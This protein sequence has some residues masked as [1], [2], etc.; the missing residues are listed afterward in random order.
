M[1]KEDLFVSIYPLFQPIADDLNLPLVLFGM[2][3]TTGESYDQQANTAYLSVNIIWGEETRPYLNGADGQNCNSIIQIDCIYPKDRGQEEL[4]ALQ[5]AIAVK[6]KIPLDSYI[7]GSVYNVTIS[8]VLR[9]ETTVQYS[10]S[11]TVK[12]IDV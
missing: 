1:T 8:P 10:V 4:K 7:A 5:T 6:D 11:V 3:S 9:D 2:D 12:Q